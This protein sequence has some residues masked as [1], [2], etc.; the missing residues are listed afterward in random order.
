MS[1]MEYAGQKDIEKLLPEWVILVEK[2]WEKIEK[3]RKSKRKK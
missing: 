1:K 2:I 3:Y